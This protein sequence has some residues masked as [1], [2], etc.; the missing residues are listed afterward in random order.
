[1]SEHR[2]KEA[3]ISEMVT[4]STRMLLS[5]EKKKV[6][7]SLARIREIFY[8]TKDNSRVCGGFSITSKYLT[9]WNL[10]EI[11]FR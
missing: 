7:T 11:D 8:D 10:W 5:A 3:E 1:M 6:Q 9:K 4:I 2:D